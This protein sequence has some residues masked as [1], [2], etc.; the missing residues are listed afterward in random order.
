MSVAI[1]ESA[2]TTGSPS[3]ALSRLLDELSSAVIELPT[4]V[5]HATFEGRV[6]GTIGEHVRHCLDHVSRRYSL[7][8]RPPRCLTTADTVEPL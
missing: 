2:R 8:M 1:V 7:R 4:E 3:F 6:S 5:Y